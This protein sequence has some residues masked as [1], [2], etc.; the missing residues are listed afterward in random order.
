MVLDNSDSKWV[1]CFMCFV[2]FAFSLCEE[3]SQNL[4]CLSK[5]LQTDEEH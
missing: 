2:C 1:N 5:P 3:L 4:L